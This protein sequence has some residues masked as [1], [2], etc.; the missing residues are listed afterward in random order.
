M[1]Y[2][3]GVDVGGTFTDLVAM[4]DE[5]KVTV[6]KVSTTPEDQSIG[7][8]HAIEKAG[9]DLSQ[10]TFFSHGATVGANAV[11]ENKGAK[12]A[13]ITTKGFRD[14]LEL[15][16]GQ[17][18]IDDPDDMYNLQMDLPQDYVGGYDPLV[19]RPLR[20]EVPERLDFRG[21]VLKPLDEEAVKRVAVEIRELDVEAVVICYLFSFM[22]PA[23]ELRTAE[24]VREMLPKVHLSVSSEILPIIRE[25][26]R[27]ST[28]TVN[29]YV[30]PIMQ[31]Y[32]ATLRDTLKAG[33]FQNE[34][35]L[36]QSSGGI[37][38]SE[39]AAKRPVYTIDSGP[40]AGVTAAAR[41]GTSLGHPDIISFDM[42]GTTAKVCVIRD[43]RP[44]VTNRFWV[45]GRYFIGAPVMDMVEIGAGGGS[46]VSVDKAGAV[47][48]GPRS[49]GAVPGPVCYQ[50][51][52]SEPTVTDADLLLGYINSQYFLGGEMTVDL[53]AA[54]TAVKQKVADP[55]GMSVAEAAHGIYRLVNANMIGAMRVVT[56]QR[57]HDPRDFSL[58]VSGGTAAVHAIPMAQELR[59]PRVIFPLTPGAFSA[60]G[61]ITADARYDVHRS[62]V[63]RSSQADPRR[64]QRIFAELSREATGK[65]EELG[66]DPEQIVVRHE[67]DM[68][69]F[70]QAHEVPV[71]IPKELAWDIGRQAD[72]GAIEKLADL[73]HEK[74]HHLY[75]HA[76]READVE[77]ITLTVAAVGPMARGAT[78]EIAE[79][80]TD[81]GAAFKGTRWVY[82]D[83]AGG[84]VDCPTYER[85]LL[86]ANNL[87]AGP[88][89][90]EQMDT[91]IVLPP[92]ETAKVDPHGTLIVDIA[93]RDDGAARRPYPGGG[94]T[95]AGDPD[96]HDAFTLGVLRSLMESVPSEM[97]EVLKRTS[98]HPIFNEVLDF[99]TALLDAE[100]RLIASSMG[101]PVH[102]GALELS[103]RAIV[104]RFRK[105]GLNEGD[106]LIHN[107]PFPGGTHLPDVDVLAPVYHDG[108]LVAYSVARG[109]HG[110]IGGMHPGSFAG[111]TTS[112]FQEGVRLPPI[113]LYDRGTLNQGVKDLFLANVRVPLFSWGDLQAQVAGC[114]LGEKRIQELFEK[115]GAE[116]MK[117]A[118]DWA[119]DYSEQLIRTEIEGIP[120]GTYTF[121]D[122]LDN[123]GI[124]KSRPVKIHVRLT[125]E[126]SDITAD[127]SGSDAQVKGPANCVL[128]VV[129]SATYCALFN[130]TDPTIP[131]NHG[132][133]RPVTI[134]AP[135][136]RVVNAKF[137][138]P[139][140]SGNTETSLRIIDTVSGA[141][142]RVIPQRVI[143]ADSGTAT[144]HIAGGFD[145][146]TG[147]YYAWYLGS[148][149]CASGAR[150]TKDG[151]QASGGP[152]IGGHVSQIPMEVFETRYPF[153]VEKY[154]YAPDSGGP[155]EFRG[156][157][158]SVT[159]MRPVDHECEIGGCN[160]RC[161]IPPYG[162][163][164]G[165]PGLHGE[166]KIIHPDGSETPID[167][168]G[169]EIAREGDVLYF[170]APGGG[171]Y[172]DP[173][174]RDLDYLQQDMDIG[175]V[176]RESARRDYGASVDETTG[177]MDRKATEASRAKLKGEWKRD[178][179]FIDQRTRPF[180]G[181]TFR[182][183]SIDEQIP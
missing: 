22:N 90:V 163:F 72:Q 73:F 44:E 137:P 61:L 29:A 145:P 104:D 28:A 79:G 176:S 76:S 102:L 142:A 4:D 27:L 167:R 119:M 81:A 139:V 100:G 144:A 180:A 34:F 129:H 105:E 1:T 96:R 124:D 135:E 169:G 140:V 3:I 136:G 59:I 56:I 8:R 86:T 74:H 5:G 82:F 115:Y 78:P 17:R 10:V 13:V 23:H 62:Y 172:G 108:E 60:V 147:E 179:I 18:V 161:V 66:F 178:Q 51:G 80:T 33:G 175:L 24:I 155:G 54:T 98:Y 16:R 31:S 63:A 19:R 149:P 181:K 94:A 2:R 58:V 45:G 156:G 141:L 21:N 46:I 183:V 120:D 154:A 69:Y 99:S 126:G 107:N 9:I 174:D 65:I 83:E 20:F 132:C 173:L 143:A 152:R 52:G 70:G 122:Y 166:N 151:F 11:I 87:I 36:M 64:L 26:E 121:E 41:L 6:A 85:S 101:V 25:Y 123:D 57:G 15:R 75:G 38:S 112:I 55:L 37:M 113:K 182:I 130:L 170:R 93:D 14:I 89:I 84:Y 168:A 50:K 165:M 42:G 53:D 7:V 43:G 77:F 177:S 162:I 68:R 97:A 150:A 118:M 67:I 91:T 32:L 106:V 128:G 158:S 88:A 47:H 117:E 134:I 109:H 39:V 171:G 12:V 48:V 114:A 138:A 160:D 111:D 133:Y 30:M 157:M 153:L 110:D 116:A 49:A 35:Y 125:I 148:D 131:K 71:E 159:I 103:A 146:R 164:G 127:F 40:A 95:M 92:G